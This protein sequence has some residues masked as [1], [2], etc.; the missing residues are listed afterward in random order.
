MG[1]LPGQTRVRWWLG[2]LDLGGGGG[3]GT[4][5]YRGGLCSFII[6]LKCTR[7]RSNKPCELQPFVTGSKLMPGLGRSSEELW[8]ATSTHKA[9]EQANTHTTSTACAK[10]L[11]SSPLSARNSQQQLAGVH[12]VLAPHITPNVE[13]AKGSKGPEQHSTLLTAQQPQHTC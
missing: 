13:H 11:L 1:G 5:A 12:D 3:G 10:A 8:P 6:L 7:A 2:P 9:T 4:Q